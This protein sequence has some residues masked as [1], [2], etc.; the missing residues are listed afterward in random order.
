MLH[1]NDYTTALHIAS[2]VPYSYTTVL[3]AFA[4]LKIILQSASAAALQVEIAANQSAAR[5]LPDIDLS[6]YT[7]R[8]QPTP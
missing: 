8:P 1:A 5:G 2:R 3:S 4:K 7:T 6:V